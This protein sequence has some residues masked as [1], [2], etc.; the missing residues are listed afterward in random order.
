MTESMSRLTASSHVT[1][2]VVTQTNICYY[3]ESY[4]LSQAIDRV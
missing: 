2:T 3:K 4:L 1:V